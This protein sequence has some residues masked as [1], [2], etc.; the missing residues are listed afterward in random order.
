LSKII[1][2]PILILKLAQRG[3]KNMQKEGLFLNYSK[4][5]LPRRPRILEVSVQEKREIIYLTRE[6]Y[7]IE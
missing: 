4:T 6:T 7:S 2:K 5:K 1:H 3:K